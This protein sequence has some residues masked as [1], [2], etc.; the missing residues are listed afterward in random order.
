MNETNE[1]KFIYFCFD[2]DFL[3]SLVFIHLFFIHQSHSPSSLCGK[4][5][6]FSASIFNSDTFLLIKSIFDNFNRLN[7]FSGKRI[8]KYNDAIFQ[9]FFFDSHT[10]QRN[11]FICKK[12]LNWIIIKCNVTLTKKNKL[13]TVKTNFVRNQ[14]LSPKQT[15]DA[16]KQRCEFGLMPMTATKHM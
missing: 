11:Y 9:N 6:I 13:I 16:N 10:K 7:G 3:Y 12:N 8:P 15:T 14:M 4:F 1:I 5:R 2:N